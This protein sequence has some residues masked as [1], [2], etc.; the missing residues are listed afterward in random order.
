MEQLKNVLNLEGNIIECG[1]DRCGTSVIMAK[2]LKSNGVSKRI[3]AV[4]L[5]GSG[6]EVTELEEER[7]LDLTQATN[8]TFTYNSF[9]YVK[10]KIERLGL[11]DI[12]IPVKGLFEDT[13]PYIDSRFCLCLIDCD[14]KKSMLYSAETIW[15]KLSKNGIMLFDDYA[16]E[17]YKGAKIAVDLFVNKYQDEITEHGLLNKLYRVKKR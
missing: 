11:N 4:D 10:N 13:L 3:Y 17:E 16:S 8:K 12:I 14:L 6:F 2:Y 1:S 7:R 9:D 15:P 5:F